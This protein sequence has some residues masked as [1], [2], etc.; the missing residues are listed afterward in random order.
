M[1]SEFRTTAFCFLKKNFLY[2]QLSVDKFIN[3]TTG[4]YY[5]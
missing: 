2:P 3:L 4:K 1:T 5:I